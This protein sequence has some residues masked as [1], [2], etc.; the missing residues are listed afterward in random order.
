[1]SYGDTAEDEGHQHRHG[2]REDDD[3]LGPRCLWTWLTLRLRLGRRLV[4]HAA[5]DTS[6]GA[7]QGGV[8]RAG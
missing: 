4:P 1:L 3:G 8:R 2:D 7:R 6:P 5:D